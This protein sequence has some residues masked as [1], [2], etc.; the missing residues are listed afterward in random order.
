ME[1]LCC[2]LG[3]HELVLLTAVIAAH[4]VDLPEQHQKADK[5]KDTKFESR[6]S[7][8]PLLLHA[9]MLLLVVFARLGC[10]L[11]PLLVAQHAWRLH[12]TL[13]AGVMC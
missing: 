7:S 4:S 9:D 11:G 2:V 6:D 3:L 5:E 10:V 13:G 8:E 1:V 12:G